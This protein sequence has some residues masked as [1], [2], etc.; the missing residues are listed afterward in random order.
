MELEPECVCIA[1]S[2]CICTAAVEC[3]CPVK[4]EPECTCTA[5][6]E[7]ICTVGFECICP[8]ELEPE[9]T[10]TVG[11]ECICTVGLLFHSFFHAN[12]NF[13]TFPNGSS[14]LIFEYIC[15]SPFLTNHGISHR[16]R[17]S[18]NSGFSGK[19]KTFGKSDAEEGLAFCSPTSEY[20]S[21]VVGRVTSQ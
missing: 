20:L 10:C 13:C 1:G 17:L 21:A 11:S 6:S 4:L 18:L 8:V 5:G 9:C 12:E 19:I 16:S 2:E 14:G 15:W 3:I 7:C